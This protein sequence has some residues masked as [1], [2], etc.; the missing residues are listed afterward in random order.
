MRSP[1]GNGIDEE[2]FD[3]LV[4]NLTDNCE[5][6][7]DDYFLGKHE[8]RKNLEGVRL[9]EGFGASS[10]MWFFWL[11]VIVLIVIIWVMNKQ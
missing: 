6:V 11:L 5:Y 9:I 4:S 3:K 8:S 7:G 2:S 10:N 1:C